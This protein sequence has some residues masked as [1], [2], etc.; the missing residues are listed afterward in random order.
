MSIILLSTLFVC[1]S[2]FQLNFIFKKSVNIKYR[3]KN[4]QQNVNKWILQHIK[5]II[6]HAKW[7]LFQECK[8]GLKLKNQLLEHTI[9]IEKR[10]KLSS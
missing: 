4:P 5:R 9:S 6:Y 1:L 7:D 3:H 10:Q 2:F 8:V